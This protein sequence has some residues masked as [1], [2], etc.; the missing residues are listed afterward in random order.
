MADSQSGYRTITVAL[1]SPADNG[2]ETQRTLILSC[3]EKCPRVSSVVWPCALSLIGCIAVDALRALLSSIG[4]E[5]LADV[6]QWRVLELGSGTGV[7]G[8]ALACLGASSVVLTDQPK[9]MNLLRFNVESACVKEVQGTQLVSQR[10]RISCDSFDWRSPP[11][12]WSSQINVLVVCECI[13]DTMHIGHSPVVALFEVFLR[14]PPPPRLILLSMETR[15]DEIENSFLQQLQLLVSRIGEKCNVI[16]VPRVLCT[17]S[18]GNLRSGL[19]Y[20]RHF[21]IV[22][23]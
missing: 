7:V 21:A 8:L 19:C 18:E 5:S 15:D 14:K 12:N 1:P 4:A 10:A 13:Y 17:P 9:C 20:Y 22:C 3:N 6:S 11:N 23:L 2:K 16:E